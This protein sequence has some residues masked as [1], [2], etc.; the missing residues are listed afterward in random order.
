MS[1][2][3]QNRPSLP[4]HIADTV[5]AI[6]EVH[7]EHY[8]RTT[9]L[10][11][12]VASITAAVGRPM[13]ALGL[14]L[15]VVAW[16]ATNLALAC[17]GRQPWDPAPFPYLAGGASLI[18]L[19]MVVLILIT[20]RYDDE[21]ARHREQLTLELAMLSERK[22]AKIIQLIEQMRQDSPHLETRADQE[23]AVMSDAVDPQRVLADLKNAYQSSDPDPRKVFGADPAR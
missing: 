2:R 7:A 19:Y 10:Q 16:I 8:Q 17:A 21:I 1:D 14:T 5:Q 22:S 3:T 11:R 18:G 6:A 9:R 12:L 23:A 15:I 20:Q 4:A 13:F